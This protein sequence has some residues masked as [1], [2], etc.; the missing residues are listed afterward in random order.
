MANIRSGKMA[1]KKISANAVQKFNAAIVDVG[2]PANLIT[3]IEDP[4]VESATEQ[5]NHA[6]V[7]VILVTGGPVVARAAMSCPK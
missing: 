3:V 6:D 2:G 5:F 4:T 1:A 7:D